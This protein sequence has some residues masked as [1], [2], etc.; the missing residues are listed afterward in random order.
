MWTAGVTYLALVALL[1]WQALRGQSVIAPDAHT[2]GAF[3][4]LALAAAAAAA[5]VLLHARRPPH[6]RDLAEI[7][8]LRS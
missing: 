3:G 7:Q 2:V 1:A 4:G 8:I 6:R 5:A